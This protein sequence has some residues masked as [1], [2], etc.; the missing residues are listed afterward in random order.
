MLTL[1]IYAIDSMV[2]KAQPS[3]CFFLQHQ[4]WQNGKKINELVGFE[5]ENRIDT[6]L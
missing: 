1:Q 2:E 3:A 6:M 4:H 5:I